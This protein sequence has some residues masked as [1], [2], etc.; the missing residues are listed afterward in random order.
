MNFGLEFREI[1]IRNA[2]MEKQYKFQIFENFPGK[3]ISKKGNSHHGS[4]T[5]MEGFKFPL[6]CVTGIHSEMWTEW[7]AIESFSSS[8]IQENFQSGGEFRRSL[9]T[10]YSCV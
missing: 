7:Q 5:I 3:I 9:H 8:C 6:D 4:L 10:S 2:R 1:P